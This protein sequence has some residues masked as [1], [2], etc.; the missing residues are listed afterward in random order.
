MCFTIH[1]NFL[2]EILR[3]SFALAAKN[4]TREKFRKRGHDKLKGRIAAPAGALESIRDVGHHSRTFPST[5]RLRSVHSLSIFSVTLPASCVILH[6]RSV[7]KCPDPAWSPWS[8]K[9][10]RRRYR[11][12]RSIAVKIIVFPSFVPVVS[13]SRVTRVLAS[14][15]FFSLFFF[16]TCPFFRIR[17]PTEL[18]SPRVETWSQTASKSRNIFSRDITRDVVHETKSRAYAE[19]HCWDRNLFLLSRNFLYLGIDEWNFCCSTEIW[20]KIEPPIFRIT[21]D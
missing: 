4:N 2:R 5:A 19:N 11:P 1:R 17:F 8:I 16:F 10:D 20:I 21:C 7:E 14:S 15:S 13:P 9:F 12:E 18:V 6:R 3:D